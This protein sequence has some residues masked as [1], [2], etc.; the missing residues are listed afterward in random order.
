MHPFATT[1]ARL[2]RTTDVVRR[3]RRVAAMATWTAPPAVAA[4]DALALA[5]G[6]LMPGA[7]L[8]GLSPVLNW[9][10]PPVSSSSSSS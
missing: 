5:V 6:R 10:P 7:A 1:Q 4:R 9:R 3:S 2:A 8:R